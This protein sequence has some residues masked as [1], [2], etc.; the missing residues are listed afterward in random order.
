[1]ALLEELSHFIRGIFDYYKKLHHEKII[2]I[3][4]TPLNHPILPLLMDMH[5]AVDA[6]SNTNIPQDYLKLEDDA[7]LQIQRAKELFQE[8]F[9]YEVDGFWPAEGAVDKS[10]VQLLSSCGIN[11]IATDAAILFKSLDSETREALY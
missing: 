4:T 3:A 11:W 10:S 2:T 6:N 8:T 1:M 5:N 9:E 7:L